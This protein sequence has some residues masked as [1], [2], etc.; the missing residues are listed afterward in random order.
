VSTVKIKVGAGEVTI[1][2]PNLVHLHSLSS[3][4]IQSGYTQHQLQSE[5]HASG[6]GISSVSL[7]QGIGREAGLVTVWSM[8]EMFAM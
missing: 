6:S 3:A 2:P 5:P 8:T 4:A 7:T 1:T